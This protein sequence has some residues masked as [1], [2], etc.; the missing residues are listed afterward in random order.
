MAGEARLHIW[1]AYWDLRVDECPCDV[2][3]C[4][5]LEKEKLTNAAIFHFGTGGH[6]IVG[7]RTAEN[8]SNNAVLGITASPQEYETFVQLAIER[9]DVEKTYKTFFGDIYQLDARLLPQFEVVTLFHLCEF[10]TEKNDAYGALT[11]RQVLD[12]LTD[13][14]KSGGT[15]LFYSGSFAYDAALRIVAEWEK[16]SPVEKVGM[17]ETLLVYRKK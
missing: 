12:M 5:W 2:Q 14:T 3:F 11:D 15:I 13:K 16:D 8:G 9:P 10:R 7:I 17:Y 6:H 1:D 4:D